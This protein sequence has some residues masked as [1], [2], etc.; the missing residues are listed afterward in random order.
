LDENPTIQTSQNAGADANIQ[1][2]WRQRAFWLGIRQGLLIIVGTIDNFI[3][4][5]KPKCRHCKKYL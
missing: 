4:G 1:P 3:L 2:G 5:L